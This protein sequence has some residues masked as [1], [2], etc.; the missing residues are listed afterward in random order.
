M[1]FLSEQKTTHRILPI[2]ISFVFLFILQYG[3]SQGEIVYNFSLESIK[4]NYSSSAKLHLPNLLTIAI[5][6]Q[7][8]FKDQ[9]IASENNKP[10]Y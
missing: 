6:D 10:K 7:P 1:K 3:Y 2:I 4:I 5:F 9:N 8:E